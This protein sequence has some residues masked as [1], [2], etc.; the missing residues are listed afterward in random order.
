MEETI[1]LSVSDSISES[2]TNKVLA[3][4]SFVFPHY[5]IEI[6]GISYDCSCYVKLKSGYS[7]DFS[8]ES[9]V[10]T[11]T[12]IGAGE[13]QRIWSGYCHASKGSVDTQVYLKILDNKNTA[14]TVNSTNN[15]EYTSEAYINNI[16]VKFVGLV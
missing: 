11:G 6:I 1:T 2:V 16:T 5:S 8:S 13:T 9:A 15:A 4:K 7:T 3:E 12:K 14:I 10:S